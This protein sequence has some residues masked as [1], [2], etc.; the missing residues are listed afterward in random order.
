M[1]V[2]VYDLITVTERR[3]KV[4]TIE[5]GCGALGLSKGWL[6]RAV[7]RGQIVPERNVAEGRNG[8]GLRGP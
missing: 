1:V 4:L 3:K 2:H 8:D 5:E 7:A 6:Y